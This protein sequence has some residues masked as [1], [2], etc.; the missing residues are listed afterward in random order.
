LLPAHTGELEEIFGVGGIGYT[1]IFIDD[2]AFILLHPFAD[3]VK[4][5]EPEFNVV[6]F[7][8]TGF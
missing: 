4:V 6:V 3:T 5:Y 8:I 2:P 7:V 1:I